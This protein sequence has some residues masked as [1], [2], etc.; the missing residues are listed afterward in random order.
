MK[1][2]RKLQMP[3]SGWNK[4]QKRVPPAIKQFSLWPRQQEGI[5]RAASSALCC[6][7][8]G[9]NVPLWAQ[10]LSQPFTFSASNTPGFTPS[11]CISTCWK[12][13]VVKDHGLCYR[14][15]WISQTIGAVLHRFSFYRI[16]WPLPERKGCV[17]VSALTFSSSK[18]LPCA[19]ISWIR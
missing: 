3:C 5:S 13:Y 14:A 7:A 16:F 2:C 10:H 9:T 18:F 4:C 19:V 11:W 12:T 15:I 6:T 8:Q 1:P 17:R